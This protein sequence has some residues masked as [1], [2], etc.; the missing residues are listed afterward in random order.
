[1]ENLHKGM[2]YLKPGMEYAKPGMEFKKTWNGIKRKNKTF[3]MQSLF[4]NI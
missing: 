4:I 2:E 1:M 3:F